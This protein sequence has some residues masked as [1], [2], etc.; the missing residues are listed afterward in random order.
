VN[1]ESDRAVQSLLLL[2]LVTQGAE[3]QVIGTPGF[4]LRFLQRLGHTR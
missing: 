1:D 2:V 4:T 3:N